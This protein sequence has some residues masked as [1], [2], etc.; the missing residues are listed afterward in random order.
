MPDSTPVGAAIIMAH[1]CLLEHA[2]EGRQT[3]LPCDDGA[4]STVKFPL[5]GR[6]LVLQLDNH[7]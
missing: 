5:S 2:S 4:L 7:C 6:E 3:I 1:A